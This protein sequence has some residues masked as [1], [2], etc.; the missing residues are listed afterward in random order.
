M[1]TGVGELLRRRKSLTPDGRLL[2]A[3]EMIG[4]E[5]RRIREEVGLVR[6]VIQSREEALSAKAPYPRRYQ[7]RSP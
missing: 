5:M 3:L 2:A 4:D 1:D 6:E 7:R